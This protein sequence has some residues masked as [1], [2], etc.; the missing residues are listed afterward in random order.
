MPSIKRSEGTVFEEGDKVTVSVIEGTYAADKI[1]EIAVSTKLR[2][3][4]KPTK[5]GE[6]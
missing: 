2:K 1:K 4:T 5:R 6:K 3:L